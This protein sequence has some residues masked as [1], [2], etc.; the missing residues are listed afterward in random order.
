MW[1]IN[2]ICEL[3]FRSKDSLEFDVKLPS[4]I[5]EILIACEIVDYDCYR[6]HLCSNERRG[7]L[8]EENKIGKIVNLLDPHSPE[9]NSVCF[10]KG[11]M[12]KDSIFIIDQNNNKD[13]RDDPVRRIDNFEINSKD[14]LIKCH[15]TIY[16][17]K[18]YVQ[19]SSWIA[20]GKWRY[21]GLFYSANQHYTS[22]FKLGKSK[23]EIEMC[24]DDGRFWFTDPKVALV[25]VK[26]SKSD[27][28]LQ[29]E[30]L[31]LGEYLKVRE[32][33]YKIADLTHDGRFLTLVRED[34]YQ[35]IAGT[36]IGSI[37]PVFKCH[38]TDGDSISSQD[39][40]GS[41]VLLINIS[42]CYSVP[43]SLEV[44]RD[45]ADKY[46]SKLDMVVID[47]AGGYLKQI[48]NWNLPGKL[49]NADTPENS[50][51]AKDYRPDYCSRTC[52]LIGA[53][54]RVVD[55]FEIFDWEKTLSKHFQPKN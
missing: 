42:A 41:P 52:F 13:F 17:G 9:E 28:V 6:Y 29:G 34:H 30:I 15:Y 32:G 39:Y 31:S 44:Y 25:G 20:F 1:Y 11:I 26:G 27:T 45:L 51:F 35:D 3:H 47:R 48:E 49:V 14:K 18:E 7:V 24:I 23:Y 8:I 21:P 37:A 2:G 22:T 55:K 40:K 43:G 54:G 46:G 19:N 53:D 50:Q 36:Q 12:G 5:S 38:T 10:L 4:D 16:N 33:I